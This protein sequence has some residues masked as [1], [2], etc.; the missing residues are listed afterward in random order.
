MMK[1]NLIYAC[2]LLSLS[3]SNAF[4]QTQAF[5]ID[6]SHSKVGFTANLAGL[7]DVDGTFPDFEGTIL[8]D[9][10]D[11]SKLSVSALI[12][13]ATIHTG[14]LHRDEHL[15]KEEFFDA[16]KYPNIEFRSNHVKKSGKKWLMS[17]TLKMKGVEKQIE[18]PIQKVHGLTKD[19]W[20]NQRIT[21]T[22]ELPIK[23]SDFGIGAADFWGSSIKNEVIIK[24]TISGRIFN[25]D[26]M[27][28]FE[29]GKPG[30]ILYDLI[31]EKGIETGIQ[32]MEEIKKTNPDFF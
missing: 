21:F 15:Q 22:A 20:D 5:D 2:F 7:V 24:L 27:S 3:C 16:Q 6:A 13:V 12:K 30:K 4:A 31:V 18:F 9:E 1:Q 29:E 32:Q 10:Q 19:P 14:E 8:Y 17:G 23:R 25:T 26:L 28:V 11:V